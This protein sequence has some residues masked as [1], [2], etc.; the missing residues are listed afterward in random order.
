M[1]KPTL[2]DTAAVIDFLANYPDAQLEDAVKAAKKLRAQ[3]LLDRIPDEMKQSVKRKAERVNG[4]Q[5]SS[6]I[7]KPELCFTITM[8]S[9]SDWVG[10]DWKVTLAN[11][12]DRRA[13]TFFELFDLNGWEFHDTLHDLAKLEPHLL[14]M[15]E[16][17]QAVRE[18]FEDDYYHLQNEFGVDAWELVEEMK[19]DEQDGN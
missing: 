6:F 18:S 12:D 19:K 16:Q 17:E 3:K 2:R 15:K 7:V 8:K 13:A 9:W 14:T 11:P 10:T 5:T 1:N 4:G